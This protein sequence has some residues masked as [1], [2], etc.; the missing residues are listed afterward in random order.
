MNKI[1]NTNT[2]SYLIF[3]IREFNVTDAKYILYIQ[4]V[5][6]KGSFSFFGA[7]N[8]IKRPGKGP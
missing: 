8:S 5:P 1:A 7:K 4:G 3:N 2:S 6:K